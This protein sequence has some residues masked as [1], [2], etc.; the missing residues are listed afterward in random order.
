MVCELVRH[1]GQQP[2]RNNS[3]PTSQQGFASQTAGV[4][5]GSGKFLARLRMAARWNEAIWTMHRLD[6]V[7][8]HNTVP[9]VTGA[10]VSIYA[11]VGVP[12]L[13]WGPT[14]EQAVL[15]PGQLALRRASVTCSSMRMQSRSIE[16]RIG[17]TRRSG[18]RWCRCSPPNCRP[19]ASH[20]WTC[21]SCSGARW[22]GSS[23]FRSGAY[24]QLSRGI[25]PLDPSRAG[26][27]TTLRASL[28]SAITGP[29]RQSADVKCED[30]LSTG[31]LASGQRRRISRLHT[32]DQRETSGVRQAP[33]SIDSATF[34]PEAKVQCS[35]TP[36]QRSKRPGPGSHQISLP[37]RSA[38]PKKNFKPIRVALIVMGEVPLSTMTAP[39]A[40]AT[41]RRP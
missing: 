26:L 14:P 27:R 36:R 20:S 18:S 13:S 6:L 38:S 34:R 15:F 35:W 2:T 28:L 37:Q 41:A 12:F 10:T 29:S 24:S 32:C 23:R 19:R 25:G 40:R 30:G 16:P 21:F 3:Y 8:R 39:A 11:Q 9:A 31:G 33:H 7:D 5:A 17:W 22:K 1:N 4:S